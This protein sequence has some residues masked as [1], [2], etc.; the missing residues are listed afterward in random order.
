MQSAFICIW[1]GDIS[2]IAPGATQLRLDIAFF[3]NEMTDPTNIN[4]AIAIRSTT[5]NCEVSL[6]RP[7]T[8]IVMASFENVLLSDSLEFTVADGFPS[9]DSMIAAQAFITVLD[10][11]SVLASMRGRLD[12][13][14][15]RNKLLDLRDIQ[16][17]T[18]S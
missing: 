18:R 7:R 4:Q 16:V 5:I 1:S 6:E 10:S 11:T 14:E 13:V 15:V 9:G 12:I 2:L 3:D 17:E 8:A